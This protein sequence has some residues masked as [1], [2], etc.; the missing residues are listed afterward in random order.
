MRADRCTL[1]SAMKVQALFLVVLAASC[2]R[3]PVTSQSGVDVIRHMEEVYSD[4]SSY[5]DTG[6]VVVSGAENHK[7]SFKTFYKAPGK[8]YFEYQE[9]SDRKVLCA[10]GTKDPNYRGKHPT[11]AWFART[12][13]GGEPGVLDHI[14]GAVATNTVASHMSA[15]QVPSL[16][17]PGA[18]ITFSTLNRWKRDVGAESV[19]GTD[20]FV[21][22]SLDEQGDSFAN[23]EKNTFWIDRRTYALRKFRARFVTSPP[24]DIV[25]TYAPKL[26]PAVP[27]GQFEVKTGGN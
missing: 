2:S 22:E 8:L 10:P 24:E 15:Q 16:L 26:N 21:V 7:V 1:A 14:S 18:M 27:D 3:A 5:S 6:E 11:G 4:L 23:L 13:V 12:Y 17:F 19:D 9:G 20:C 25:I